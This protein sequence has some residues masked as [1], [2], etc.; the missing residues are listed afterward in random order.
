[1]FIT[2]AAVGGYYAA[3]GRRLLCAPLPV[4][5]CAWPRLSGT[6]LHLLLRTLGLSS[7]RGRPVP[8]STIIQP[9]V[10]GVCGVVGW[11]GGAHDGGGGGRRASAIK[12][13]RK[14]GWLYHGTIPR[15]PARGRDLL[16][17]GDYID[18]TVITIT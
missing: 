7:G 16:V 9:G 17:G 14:R 2:R 12:I 15:S 10:R 6:Y 4:A 8:R 11:W 5:P 3:G 18:E 13:I 1:M